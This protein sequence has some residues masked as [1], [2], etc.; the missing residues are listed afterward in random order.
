MI[1]SQVCAV[2]VLSVAMLVDTWAHDNLISALDQV[3]PLDTI[4]F[5]SIK[6]YIAQIHKIC[7]L[8]DWSG[9]MLAA[10][11]LVEI[12]W[13]LEVDDR[14]AFERMLAQVKAEVCDDAFI[15]FL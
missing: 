14:D 6:L 2:R 12:Q 11:C 1:H 15:R 3:I 4:D 10:D 8:R 5:P 7:Q 9:Y 13:R